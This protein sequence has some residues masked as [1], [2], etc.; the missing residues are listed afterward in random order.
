MFPAV[1][2][3]TEKTCS[4][5]CTSMWIKSKGLAA[6]LVIKRLAGIAPEVNLRNQLHTGDKARTWEI[7]SGFETK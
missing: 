3:S 1:Y 2:Y 7:H 4:C 5:T 6:M